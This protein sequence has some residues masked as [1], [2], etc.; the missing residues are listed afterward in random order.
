MTYVLVFLSGKGLHAEDGVSKLRPA[1]EEIF[2]EYAGYCY[3]ALFLFT[4][5]W[6]P[7]DAG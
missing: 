7:L 2:D 3:I 4:Y 1:L 5:S 6:L